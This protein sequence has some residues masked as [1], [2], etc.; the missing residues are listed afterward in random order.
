MPIFKTDFGPYFLGEDA[1]QGLDKWLE[2]VRDSYSSVVILTDENVHNAVVPVILSELEFL[3]EASVVEVPP[4]EDSKS[5][6]IL[7]H[8]WLALLENRMDRHGLLISIGGG[9][10]TDLGGFL[11]AT[12][13]R[14]IDHIAV[15]TTLLG[16]VDASIGGKTGINVGGY[17]N[18][19]GN[20]A[21]SCGI[22]AW[23]AA[24]ESLP[25]DEWRCGWAECIKH[26]FIKGGE[27]W[28]AVQAMKELQAV[29]SILPQ[30]VSV[31]CEVIGKDPF[32]E[33]SVRMALN[34]GHTM[35]HALESA[36]NGVLSHG[37]CVA[38]G[39]WIESI[40]A[41][42]LGLLDPKQGKALRYLIDTWWTNRLPIPPKTISYLHGDKKNQHNRIRFILPT[43]AGQPPILT[44][45]PMEIVQKALEIYV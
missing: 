6:E 8:L 39:L 33:S 26:A 11:S 44:E 24:L 1:L 37:D 3:G 38:A 31:K 15:P 45:V 27:L 10:I 14:G 9:V 4:G 43:G 17:K 16:M 28:E 22:Y 7:G 40:M 25:E 13:M 35:G 12:Y 32:E 34:L 42:E 2:K 30:L 18:L 36:S 23:P 21:K 19:A 20:F 41:E 5:L 29:L